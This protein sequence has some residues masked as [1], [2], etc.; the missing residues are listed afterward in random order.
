MV[1]R[2]D[3]LHPDLVL[4]RVHPSHVGEPECRPLD[5]DLGHRRRLLPRRPDPPL[6]HLVVGLV[7]PPVVLAIQTDSQPVG[8]L[9]VG[10]AR[11]G[12]DPQVVLADGLGHFPGVEQQAG[13]QD[14]RQRRRVGLADDVF[15]DDDR[16]ALLALLEEGVGQ[17]ELERDVLGRAGQGLA[18]LSLGLVGVPLAEQPFGQRP[19]QGEVVRGDSQRLPQHLQIAVASHR[20]LPGP[21]G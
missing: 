9:A 14:V 16:Q 7:R 21:R 8:E 3:D 4:E 2:V 12:L 11:V 13:V 5:P 20:V 6:D 18:E 10:D 1:Q 15:H 17:A 19:P